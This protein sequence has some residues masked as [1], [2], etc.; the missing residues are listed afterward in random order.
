M[1]FRTLALALPA[2]MLI[3]AAAG[4][5]DAPKSAAPATAAAKPAAVPASPPSK[6]PAA[7]PAARKAKPVDINSATAEQLK[8]VPGIGDAEAERIIRNRPYPTR[9]HLADRKVLTL[10]QYYAL[11]DH[12]VAVPPKTTKAPAK[13]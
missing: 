13:K 8:T 6:A 2:A 5:A 10:E 12:F 4:A 3:A 9:S 11:K 1:K 7:K